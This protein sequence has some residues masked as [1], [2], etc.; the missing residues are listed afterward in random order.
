[1]TN[2]NAYL[3][4]LENQKNAIIA[5]EL[6]LDLAR[7]NKVSINADPTDI[8]LSQANTLIAEA[9]ESI[10]VYEA[11]LNDYVIKA[12]FSGTITD[13][14]MKIG[15]VADQTKT[16]RLLGEESFVLK[17]R[18]PEVDIRDIELGDDV[19]VSFDA[20]PEEIIQGSI[21]FV[22]PLSTK[23][24]GV[25]YYNTYINLINEPDWLREGLNADIEII[26]E[27][28]RDTLVV[29]KQFIETLDGKS[30]VYTLQNNQII[31]TPVTLGIIGT[32]GYVEVPTLREGV[33]LTLPN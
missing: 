9:N 17:A 13:I 28:K 26:L 25:S 27:M 33:R 10:A 32:D 30:F 6:S 16:I 20:S 11:R 4:V 7:Q 2:N 15:E 18:I 5:A 22:S 23:I 12:P 3:L 14:D 21:N 29:P 31:W 8:S 19:L 1:M 24:S